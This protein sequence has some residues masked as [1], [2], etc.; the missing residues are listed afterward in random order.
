MT[1]HRTAS[2]LSMVLALTL[3]IA[4][5]SSGSGGAP[6]AD[7]ASPPGA[8][9]SE[10]PPPTAGPQ[11]VITSPDA[12]EIETTDDAMDLSGSASSDAG[13]V[14]VEWETDHGES[15]TATGTETWNIEGVP[16]A[17]GT[18]TI[19][20]TVTDNAGATH[21]DSLV[22]RR[23]SEG[24]GSATLSWE[25]PT[26]RADGTAL[27]DLAGYRIHYGRMSGV[28][29]YE[30]DIATP[31][32]TTYVVENLVP[33]DWYFAM[34]AYDTQGLESELSNEAHRAIQ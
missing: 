14:S 31:G 13:I 6:P 32:V 30:I 4:A 15:G 2:P 24:T 34:I 18:T 8:G 1:V 11:V 22:V 5:C 16:I 27:T 25:P 7:P 3:S 23:E 17:L 29:D 21:S 20:V 12:A 19:T 10:Q 26:E 33:G 28:Y 9:G